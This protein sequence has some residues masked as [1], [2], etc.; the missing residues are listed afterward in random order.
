MDYLTMATL[1]VLVEESKTVFN[2]GLC[3]HQMQIRRY[4]NV[5]LLATRIRLRVSTGAAPNPGSFHPM[6]LLLS[7]TMEQARITMADYESGLA[8]TDVVEQCALAAD[9]GERETAYHARQGLTS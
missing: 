3:T 5:F 7:E 6:P 9:H 4:G 2:H 8:L 1:S